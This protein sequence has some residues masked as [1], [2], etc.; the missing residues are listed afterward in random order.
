MAWI[1]GFE[2]TDM[3]S[4]IILLSQDSILSTSY[5][6]RGFSMLVNIYTFIF[7]L[8]DVFPFGF[9]LDTYVKFRNCDL[10]LI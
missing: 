5:V 7:L 3:A 1:V 8:I 2:H 4:L 6:F 10:I 9:N